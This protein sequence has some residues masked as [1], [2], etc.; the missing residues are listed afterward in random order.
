MKI[1][2]IRYFCTKKTSFN[3]LIF[4]SAKLQE[5]QKKITSDCIKIQESVG[6]EWEDKNG[7]IFFS[8]KMARETRLHNKWAPDV[9]RLKKKTGGSSL[10]LWS[11][12]E[13]RRHLARVS[14]LLR[15]RWWMRDAWRDGGERDQILQHFFFWNY[16]K[17]GTEYWV[18]SILS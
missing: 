2:K 14:R 7:Y 10:S 1:F 16:L 5:Q 15:D 4:S 18:S 11:L 13:T 8:L 6:Y 12:S 17:Q 9:F 3:A